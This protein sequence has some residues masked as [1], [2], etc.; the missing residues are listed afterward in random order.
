M[1]WFTSAETAAMHRAI[2]IAASPDAPA[3]PNP[4]VGCVIL[5]A[6][7]R[8]LAE[9]HHRGAGTAHAE[10]D[11]LAHLAASGISAYGTTAVVTLEPCNHYGRTGPC[12]QALLDAGVTDVIYAQDDPTTQARGGAAALA[13]A[14]VHVRSGLCAD[15]AAQLNRAWLLAVTTGRPMVTW[16]LA[17]T[18]DGR[19]AAADT[20]SRW[21]TPPAARHDA[22]RL[23]RQ[24]DAIMVGTGT[25]L[26]DDPALTIRDEAG[27]P[28]PPHLQPLRVVVGSRPI[29]STAQVLA[30]DNH[31]LLPDHDPHAVL[32]VLASREI[33][34][35]LLE[36]G[37]TLAAAFLRAGV[38]DEV[39]AY[40]APALLGAGPAAV[41]DFGVSTIADIVRLRHPRVQ[42]LGEGDDLAIRLAGDPDPG[43][44][45]RTAHP[46][47]PS[48]TTPRRIADVHR[49][50]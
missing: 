2:A 13:A 15:E 50:C 7:G 18:L 38:V 33:R 40:V 28:A 47:P 49:N 12:A 25:A 11:A 16:K 32:A 14:G 22:H 44:P 9:G 3:G 37:P 17:A 4:R 27:Q 46:S 23:R 42:V 26:A 41:A 36:G 1:T 30:D 21:I 5:S 45:E 31:L 48:T 8:V 35:V 43:G 6:A 34:H 20:T 19:I 29:P 24:C 10:V 39:V